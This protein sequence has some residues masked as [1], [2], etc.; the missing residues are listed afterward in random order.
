MLESG[1]FPDSLTIAKIIPLYKK[2]NIN[3]ITNYR[4]ISLLPTLSKVF[5]HVILNQL[6]TYR[7]H[8][9]FLSEQQYGFRAN[10]TAEQ[11]TIKLVD[12]IVHEINRKLTPV[13]I[14][15]DLSKSFDTLN[16][17]ILLYKLHYYGIT[18]IALK[19]LKSYM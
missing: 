1:I 5:E 9:Y 18:G 15:I 7:D 6:Y 3:S 4:P 14:Y 19:L 16:F 13:N 11:V 17:D 12:Y 10:H 2:L 8:K